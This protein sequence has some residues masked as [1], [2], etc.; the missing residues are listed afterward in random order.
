M[1]APV[2][3]FLLVLLAACGSKEPK[4]DDPAPQPPANP[5]PTPASPKERARIHTELGAGY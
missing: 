4:R 1:K 5:T 3:L 2:A